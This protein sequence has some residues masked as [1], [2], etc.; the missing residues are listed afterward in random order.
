MG[1]GLALKHEFAGDYVC[2]VH[3]QMKGTVVVK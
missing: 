3:P 2:A 1:S